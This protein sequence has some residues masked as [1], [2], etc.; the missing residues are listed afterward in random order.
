M[1]F[2]SMMHEQRDLILCMTNTAEFYHAHVEPTIAALR[3]HAKRGD[4]DIREAVK[5]WR[6]V[7]DAGAKWYVKTWCSADTIWF[8][9]FTPEDRDTVA[10]YLEETERENVYYGL[11]VTR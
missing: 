3:R 4:Y 9:F 8:R 10:A 7:A 11:E 6:R 1:N 5:A 2:D